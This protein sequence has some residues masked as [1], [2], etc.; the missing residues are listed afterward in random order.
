M[1]IKIKSF[2]VVS[3]TGLS[4]M[5]GVTLPTTIFEP[6]LTLQIY[7]R[8]PEPGTRN[9]AFQTRNPEPRTLSP[10]FS[11]ESEIKGGDR[12]TYQASLKTGDYVS[13]QFTQKDLP[14]VYRLIGPDGKQILE[15]DGSEGDQSRDPISL[16]VETAGDYRFEVSPLVSTAAPGPYGIRVEALRP[17]TP[18]DLAEQEVKKLLEQAQKLRNARKYDE[19]VT[20]ATQALEKCTAAFGPE[21]A[22]ASDCLLNMSVTYG[23]KPDRAKAEE[24]YLKTIA[25]REKVFGPE[26]HK[27]A[28]VVYRYAVMLKQ[29]GDFARAEPV[30]KRALAIREKALGPDHL[31][32]AVSL[33]ALAL[34]YKDSGNYAPAEPYYLRA[35]AIA[36]KIHGPV[37]ERVGNFIYQL[38]LFYQLRGDFDRA[39]ELFQRTHAIWETTLGPDHWKITQSLCILASLY[40]DTGEYAK[41]E[42]L[43]NRSLALA[44]K[45]G[46]ESNYVAQTLDLLASMYRARGDYEKAEPYYQRALVLWEKA[47]GADNP[48]V[49]LHL[50]NLGDLYRAMG[51]FAKAEPLYQ[52]ALVLREKGFGKEHRFVADCIFGQAELAKEKGD[53]AQAEALH[54]KVLAMREKLLGP[55]HIEVALSLQLLAAI[56]RQQGKF[57]AAEPLLNRALNIRERALGLENPDVAAS[58][59]DLALLNLAEGNVNQ[60][61]ALLSKSN[62]VTERDLCRNL[63]TGSERQKLLYL[64]TTNPKTDVTISLH[65]QTA[66]KNRDALRAGLTVVLRRKGRGLDAMAE[67]IE[68]LQRRAA[69]ED[70]GL[71]SELARAKT[72]L[73]SLILRGPDTQTSEAYQAQIKDL[74]DQV[75]QIEAKVSVRSAEYRAQTQPISLESIQ[76]AVPDDAA[77]VEFVSYRPY[78]AKTDTFATRHYLAYVLTRTGDPKWADLGEAEPIE[79]AVGDLRQTLSSA[80]KDLENEVKPAARKLEKLVMKP[81]RSLIGSRKHLLIS[82]DGALNLIP[83][84]ALMDEKGK[85]LVETYS[86]TYL[87]S[88]R[89]L[90]RLQVKIESQSPALVMADPDYDKGA[91]PKL[92]GQSFSPLARLGGTHQEGSQL[93][94]LFAD[95]TLKMEGEA[96]KQ[97]LKS[98]VKPALVHIATH[99]FFLRETPQTN[100]VAESGTRNLTK[101]QSLDLNP[102]TVHQT[103]P[104]LRSG[105]FFAGANRGGSQTENDSTLTALE[106]ASLNLWGTKLVTLSACDTGLGDVKVGDGVYGLRRALVLAGSESQM[107]SLWPV[108][109]AATRDLMVGYY[110][111]LKAGEGRS[112]ALRQVQLKML[113]SPVRRHPY[114]WASFIQSG[115]WANL[116]GKR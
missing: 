66:P 73:S 72:R 69:P 54:V 70:R 113:K 38:G 7:A 42:P 68:E 108:S 91:G 102:E 33:N 50:V 9:P 21:T 90:L 44:E 36:E 63:V 8:N 93:K 94:A 13:V 64:V 18:Q 67:S 43:L 88:G 98:A 116:D 87:T 47:R 58:L 51:E 31:E 86:L 110:Q 96:T 80:K 6:S 30:Y 25:L 53:L 82:P 29:G 46:P 5:Q 19:A 10:G 4:L 115:E 85:F 24:Y 62:D 2:V 17:A 81:V 97:A 45:I 76:K 48:S 74:T 100:S 23:S 61:I 56:Y 39:E 20:T 71:L 65:A 41:A 103:N 22:L 28:G 89:D 15:Q 11:L 105:L 95:A 109:D 107:M 112:Q 32:V 99:G 3:L 57:A 1:L 40:L 75:D 84:A 26:H 79:A 12:H 83:F 16:L 37:H 52:R 55:D 49:A 114:Y 77:L 78:D 35:C 14:L 59:T 106:A 111:R 101:V 92:F 104:L 34:L 27:V 60:T